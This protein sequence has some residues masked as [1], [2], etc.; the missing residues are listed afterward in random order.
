M[1]FARSM[2]NE[3]RNTKFEDAAAV[4][5]F[6]RSKMNALFVDIGKRKLDYNGSLIRRLRFAM[7]KIQAASPELK[8]AEPV[9]TQSQPAL[10]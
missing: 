4:H 5:K 6:V 7:Q 1:K 9:T 3:M 2:R 8:P 10:P